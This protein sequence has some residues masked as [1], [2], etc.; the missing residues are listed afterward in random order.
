M[1]ASPGC[2]LT[3]VAHR[4]HED[5]WDCTTPCVTRTTTRYGISTTVTNYASFISS[6][7]SAYST[8]GVPF[9]GPSIPVYTTTA[10]FGNG[11]QVTATGFYNSEALASAG[12]SFVT[13]VTN[14]VSCPPTTTPTLP[15]SPTGSLC[16]PHGDHCK[17][18]FLCCSLGRLIADCVVKGTAN[19]I[20][21]LP[22]LAHR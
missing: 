18:R 19:H 10:T 7:N 17:T 16:S 3:C 12:F 20:R 21:Q 9:S 13:T 15:P 14:V 5:H 22:P 2:R 1:L 4:F 6:M 8:S 11:A